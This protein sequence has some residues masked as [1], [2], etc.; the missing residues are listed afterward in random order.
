MRERA[1]LVS[2]RHGDESLMAEISKMMTVLFQ[3]L[4]PVE[5]SN[6]ADLIR[7]AWFDVGRHL[8]HA[9]SEYPIEQAIEDARRAP[10]LPRA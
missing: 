3:E 9:M 7:G 1:M 2:I 10:A 8:R 6:P 5:P 4:V